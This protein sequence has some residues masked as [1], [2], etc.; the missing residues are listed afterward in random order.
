MKK[1]PVQSDVSCAG[2]LTA[3]TYLTIF[4]FPWKSLIM[5]S[6]VSSLSGKEMALTGQKAV[7]LSQSTTQFSGSTTSTFPLSGL[8]LYTPFGQVSMHSPQPI[9]AEASTVA[10]HGI[11]LLGS[12]RYLRPLIYFPSSFS[13]YQASTAAFNF[14][15]TASVSS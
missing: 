14:S 5:S 11:S 13:A 7:H 1:I 15:K 12:P 8:N 3:V 10:F 2:I 4:I 6:L 9:Q